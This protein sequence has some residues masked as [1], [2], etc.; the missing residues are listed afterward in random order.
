[1]LPDPSSLGPVRYCMLEFPTFTRKSC[2]M[3]IP[4]DIGYMYVHEVHVLTSLVNQTTPS[5]ALDVALQREWS[6]SR[7]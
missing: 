4:G 1:M 7:D 5:A 2:I 6:G 3:V